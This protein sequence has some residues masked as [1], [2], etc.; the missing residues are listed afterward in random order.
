MGADEAIEA[1]AVDRFAASRA[2]RERRSR[3]PTPTPAQRPTQ[4]P[5][6]AGAGAPPAEESLAEANRLAHN[7][8]SLDALRAALE[9]FDGCPLKAT[10]RQ[11]V[12]ADGVPGAPVM[13]IGEA[14][15]AEEDR[16]GKPF[17][18]QSGRLLDAMLAAIGLS[19]RENAYITNIV[20]WRP[21][22]NKTPGQADIVVCLPF[23]LKHIALADPK[24]VVVLGNVAAKALLETSAGITNLRGRWQTLADGR[25][26]L[27]TYHPAHLLRQPKEKQRTWQDLLSLSE[28]LEAS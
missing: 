10:A 23:V 9:R 11:M 24:V 6:A 19:R 15:G 4:P 21:L 28:R 13:L 2:V 26:V 1:E 18:G 16:Q 12:F 5:P 14:P 7:A 22:D 17:V 8:D 3:P 25:P 20:P 27:P